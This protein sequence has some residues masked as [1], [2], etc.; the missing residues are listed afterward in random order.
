MFDFN[1]NDFASTS[2]FNDDFFDGSL[3]FDSHFEFINDSTLT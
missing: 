3:D 1:N 2:D